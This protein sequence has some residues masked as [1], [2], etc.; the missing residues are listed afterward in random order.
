MLCRYDLAFVTNISFKIIMVLN[1]YIDHAV[2]VLTR[3]REGLYLRDSQWA[4]EDSS[5]PYRYQVGQ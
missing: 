4:V 5:G 3:L 1:F 2:I